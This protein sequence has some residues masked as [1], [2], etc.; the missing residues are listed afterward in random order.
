MPLEADGAV[1]GAILLL[2]SFSRRPRISLRLTLLFVAL[3]AVF[4]AWLGARKEMNR[5]LLRGEIRMREIDRDY[6]AT[7]AGDA[8]EGAHWRKSMIEAD[9]IIVSK[10]IQ[11]GEE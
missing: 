7:K 9:E 4:F 8:L 2:A 10:R 11:L 6:A 3:F 1:I 5:T